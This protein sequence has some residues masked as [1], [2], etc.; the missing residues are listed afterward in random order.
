VRQDL[1]F[2]GGEDVD[3]ELV[4]IARKL[5]EALKLE[6]QMTDAGLDYLVEADKYRGG[7]IF[8]TERIG[9]FFYVLPENAPI[10]RKFLADHG[11]RAYVAG[12]GG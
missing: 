10:V 5:K 8:Q 7:L 4:Y 6:S 2:F 11:Y 12:E 3:L 9:A 1:A